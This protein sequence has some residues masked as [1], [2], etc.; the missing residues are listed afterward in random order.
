MCIVERSPHDLELKQLGWIY[1]LYFQIRFPL[2]VKDEWNRF[3]SVVVITPDFDF[4]SNY[5]GNPSSNLG[6]TSSAVF[7]RF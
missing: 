7:L 5:S 2:S 3:C 1:A 6:K 4:F